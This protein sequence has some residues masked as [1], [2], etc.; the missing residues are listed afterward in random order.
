LK[1]IIEKNKKTYKKKDTNLKF[2]KKEL[3]L[4]YRKPRGTILK[5]SMPCTD[6]DGAKK[7]EKY[8]KIKYI[9][10]NNPSITI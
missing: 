1:D 5:S 2:K 6:F 8:K 7:K 4:K 10:F 3:I 9:L